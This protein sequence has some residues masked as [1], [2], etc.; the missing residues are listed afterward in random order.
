MTKA[1]IFGNSGSGKSTLAKR[2]CKDADL[3]HL[4]LDTLAW[5][6]TTPPA[7]KPLALSAAAIHAFTSEHSHWVIEGCYADLIAMASPL[8]EE[9]IFLDISTEDCIAHAHARPWEPHKYPTK[10]A[11]DANLEMLIEWIKAYP[12]RDDSCSRQAHVEVFEGFSGKK[13]RITS[14]SSTLPGE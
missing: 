4:D 1:L 6:P 2:L 7:R 9:L 12:E 8:A 10:E 5:E 14:P 13:T 3:A 11:Q